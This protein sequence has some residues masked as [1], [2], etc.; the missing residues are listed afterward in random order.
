MSETP[1]FLF[2]S[3]KY[4]TFPWLFQ[5]FCFLLAM[6]TS[7]PASLQ[8]YKF[9]N[10]LFIEITNKQHPIHI[11]AI[12]VVNLTIYFTPQVECNIDENGT[13]ISLVFAPANAEYL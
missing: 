2:L 10:R 6:K 8:N 5:Q 3:P 9:S 7:E 13:V 12:A 1:F 11:Y 4:F